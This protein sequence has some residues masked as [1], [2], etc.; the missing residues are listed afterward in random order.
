MSDA[1]IIQ[2][3]TIDTI[4]AFATP[5]GVDRVK[6]HND[7]GFYLRVYFG[8]GAPS[9]ANATGWHATVS[10]GASPVL[11][12]VGAAYGPVGLDYNNARQAG[13]YQG[14]VIILPFLPAGGQ[15]SSGGV[16]SGGAFCYLTSFYPGEYAEPGGQV[17]AFVQAA[18]QGR[19]QE[20]TGAVERYITSVAQT[21]ASANMPTASGASYF[22]LTPARC[23]GL[24]AWAAKVKGTAGDVTNI[25]VHYYGMHA[26]WGN[27]AAGAA[28]AVWRIEGVIRDAADTLDKAVETLGV[29]RAGSAAA[30]VASEHISDQP[31]HPAMV[32][33]SVFGPGAGGPGLASGDIFRVRYIRI[34]TAG[35]WE[36]RINVDVLIDEL[37]QS[38]H[39]DRPYVPVVYAS[40]TEAP[41]DANGNPQTW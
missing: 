26:D 34:A 16:V 2:S 31:S 28:S 9:S 22:T 30:P 27:T 39:M 29:Y 4:A 13:T 14:Q 40:P 15:L 12:V 32:S 37:N 11:P 10:P 25:N 1:S 41:Y 33:L 17:D 5:T 8:L 23:P 6:V 19:Y 18:K 20:V 36:T 24:F 3:L 38:G 21:D 35:T 7:S